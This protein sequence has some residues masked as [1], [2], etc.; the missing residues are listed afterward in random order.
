[1]SNRCTLE[2]GSVGSVRVS[3]ITIEGTP[4]P[5]TFSSTTILTATVPEAFMRTAGQV[6]IGVKNPPPGGGIAT[7]GS[8]SIARPKPALAGVTPSPATVQLTD[9]TV[10]LA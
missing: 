10:Q 1:M 6:Q 3:S 4:I 7:G 8:F 9:L 5:T 2:R